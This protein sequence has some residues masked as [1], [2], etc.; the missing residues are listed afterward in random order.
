MA[1][2]YVRYLFASDSMGQLYSLL[3]SEQLNKA[4]YVAVLRYGRPRPFIL[5]EI[6]PN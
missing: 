4:I 1:G 3:R 2:I 6:D 5:I